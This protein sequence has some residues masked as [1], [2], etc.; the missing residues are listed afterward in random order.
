MIWRSLIVTALCS[1]GAAQAAELR[2]APEYYLAALIDSS[3][4]QQLALSCSDLSVDP[5]RMARLSRDIIDRLEADGFTM[6]ADNT[7]MA[8]ASDILAARQADF[9]SKHGLQAADEARVCA[10]GRAEIAE[11][12]GMGLLLID[13][14]Q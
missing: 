12:S 4:A 5:V 14:A 9:V 3:T 1:A 11:G 10:A 6:T 2:A 8:D 13:L 7:G